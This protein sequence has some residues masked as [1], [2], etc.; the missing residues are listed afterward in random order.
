M[1]EPEA[2]KARDKIKKV[3]DSYG[4]WSKVTEDL[5][6]DLKMITIEVQIKVDGGKK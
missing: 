4:L 3:I 5:R 6:P 1:T 2:Q